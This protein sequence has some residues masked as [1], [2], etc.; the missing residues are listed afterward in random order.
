MKTL[1][2]RETEERRRVAL[3]MEE[4]D[5]IFVFGSNQ[6]GIHGAGA[7]RVA[8]RNYGAIYGIG[9]GLVGRSYALPTK[10]QNV[11]TLT[12]RQIAVHVQRFLT[13][14]ENNRYLTFVVTRVG[15]GLAGY[16][17]IDIAPLFKGAPPNCKLPV[18][19][20]ELCQ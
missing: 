15:C 20:R 16:S 2:D 12:L 4:D 11:E 19:W 3:Y 18:G 8:H 6:A 5:A 10:D 14:A 17:D 9:E 1:V 13:V 7:A